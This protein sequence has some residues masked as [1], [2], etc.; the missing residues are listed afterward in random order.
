M[1][2]KNISLIDRLKPHYKQILEKQN[3]KF[4]EI[5]GQISQD[6]ENVSFV[7]DLKYKTVLELSFILG[8]KNPFIYF[9]DK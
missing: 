2:Y 6:L 5:V 1:K 3:L 7:T 4:P 9:K 8:S